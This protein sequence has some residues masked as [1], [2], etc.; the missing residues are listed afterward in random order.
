MKLGT[1]VSS[2]SVKK[3]LRIKSSLALLYL[4]V[5]AIDSR[6]RTTEMVYREPMQHT[7]TQSRDI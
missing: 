7:P 1:F 3:H 2:Q 5:A 4:D 6:L